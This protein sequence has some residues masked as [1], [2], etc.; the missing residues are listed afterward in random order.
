MKWIL[1]NDKRKLKPCPACGSRNVHFYEIAD[2]EGAWKVKCAE[3]DCGLETGAFAQK[4]KRAYVLWQRIPRRC[5]FCLA[6]TGF[7]SHRCGNC[8][9]KLPWEPWKEVEE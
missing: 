1:K 3:V 6:A 5:P 2:M 4:G 8:G 9:R 7:Y